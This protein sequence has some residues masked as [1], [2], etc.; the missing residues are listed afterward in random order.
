V[1]APPH[2]GLGDHGKQL[3]RV[4]SAV[5][6]EERPQGLGHVRE[7]PQV[8]VELRPLAAR[9]AEENLIVQYLQDALFVIE[10]LRV[11]RKIGLGQDRITVLP[12][13]LLVDA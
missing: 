1:W 3:I 9:L 2:F 13:L 4:E 6:F 12:A 11:Q 8:F 10:Q 7:A 5:D